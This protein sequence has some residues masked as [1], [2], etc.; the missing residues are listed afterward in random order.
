MD[1]KI[2]ASILFILMMNCAVFSFSQDKP[3]IAIL[4]FSGG[5]GDD[6]ETIAEHL[7]YERSLNT[8]FNVISRTRI[9]QAIRSEQN[10]QT[11]SGMTDPNT[12]V[13]IGNQFG[14][15]YVVA[16]NIT[17]LG[18]QKLLI[19]SIIKIDDIRLIAG[20]IQTY[21]TIKD[22]Q[23][24][25]PNMTANIVS[26][27]R[28]NREDL[29]ELAV[30]PF[31]ASRNINENQA[32]TL[33]QILA[34]NLVKSGK[35]AIYPRTATLEQVQAEY[36]NQ[37]SG[38]TADKHIIAMG[39]G[40][41]PQYVLS[42]AARRSSDG[43]MNVFNASIFDLQTGVQTGGESVSYRNIDHGI[44]QMEYLALLL[45]DPKAAAAWA[46][47]S[48]P[49][50]LWSIGISIGTS[51]SAPWIIGSI[52]GTIAPFKNQF[53]ELGIDYGMISGN[54]D[55]ESYYSLY[56]FVHYAFFIPFNRSGGWY[57]GAGGGYMLGEYVFPEE[58]ISVNIF[59]FDLITG[60]NIANVI[61]ISY[62]MRTD[63]K[64]V[65]NK[66][67]VGYIYRFK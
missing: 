1:K 6:G 63:F 7:S 55:A 42:G 4:P 53:L 5:V 50:K 57:A 33:A 48:D 21:N 8:E 52:H 54:S 39:R 62:T 12:I 27:V 29:P 66:L 17:K 67:A 34:I 59:A 45:T 46:M 16:G 3:V 51:F 15:E 64:S 41:N 60:I 32:E 28:N 36:R 18:K 2:R 38:N 65:S 25:L 10:F 23:S 11:A 19:I 58:N 24:V 20:D 37:L 44:H 14:A 61:N 47:F 43:S 30:L 49:V 9:S 40:I 13:S 26:A 22:I 31:M 35:Y 56:P